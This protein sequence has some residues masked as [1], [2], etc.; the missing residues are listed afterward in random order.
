VSAPGRTVAVVGWILLALLFAALL[1]AAAT[2][3]RSSGPLIGD[4]ATYAMQAASLAFDGDLV[5]ER[6]D[7][8]RF[9]AQWGR[10]PE[11]LILQ[12]RSAGYR[13]VYSKDFLYALL[14][15][16]AVRLAPVHGPLVVNV[17]LLAL[18]AWL[19]ARTLERRVGAAAPLWVAAFLFASVSFAYAFWVHA[20]LFLL[21]A[22]AAGFALAYRG[23]PRPAV[24]GALPDV[25]EPPRGHWESGAGWRV[26]LRWAAVGVLLAMPGAH[27]PFYL[28]LLLPA[29]FAARAEAVDERGGAGRRVAA[30]VAGAVLLLALVSGVQWAAGGHWSAYG[31]ERQGFYERTGFPEVDFPAGEW[32]SSV[33]RWGNTSWFHEGAV[34]SK[35]DLLDASLWGWN[36]VYFLVG[37]DVGVLPYFLPLVLVLPLATTDRGRW[38]LPLAVLLAVVAFFFM[39]P[40]NFYG[41]GGALAN[42]YFLPLYPAL[43]FLAGRAPAGRGGGRRAVAA[44]AVAAAAAPFLW[45]LWTAPRAFPIGDD[46][47]YHHVSAVARR[48]LPFETTQS[49]LPGGRDRQVEGLWLRTE[50]ALDVVGDAYVLTGGEPGQLLIAAPEPQEVVYLAF[51]PGGPTQLEVGGAHVER[52]VL[53]TD[54]GTGF[55]LRFDGPRA[56]H[57]MWWTAD[58]WYLYELRLAPAAGQ[59]ATPFTLHR[60]GTLEVRPS[61]GG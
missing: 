29:F 39:R 52:T 20:D 14:T 33:R 32:E 35:L 8:D 47:R 36:A 4:E 12:S 46:G 28:S 42:R 5:Y 60:G 26:L 25:Y 37:R 50:A 56:V 58:D 19:A 54:R 57:P 22:S 3:D 13:L 59:P 45:P 27:R 17:L 30:L 48:F 40:F 23:E 1:V 53:A 55:L 49:H 10:P 7:Y 2:A 6:G 11:G 18:A 61:G 21:A 15:A 41:G 9:V 44:L 24:G 51:A 16:P 34:T 43:W 31:G 38:A